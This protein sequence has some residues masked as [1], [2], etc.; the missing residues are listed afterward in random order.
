MYTWKEIIQNEQQKEYY[1][2]LMRFLNQAYEQSTVYP[3]KDQ[4]FT[5]FDYCS[6]E[7]VKV[8]IL[9]QDPYHG[10]HQA[11]GLCFSVLKGTKIPPSLKNIYKEL[12]SDLGID[13]PTHGYLA[14]WAKQ[15]VFLLNAVMSVEA[16]KAG[17]HQKKGWETFTDTI[18]TK[19]NEREKGI[20]FVLWGNWAIKKANLITNPQHVI[21]TSAH[22]SPLSASRGF[23]GSKPFSKVNNALIHMHQTPIDWRIPE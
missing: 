18:I 8:V 5:C 14:S 4:L 23:L 12:K 21:I 11:H 3:P 10:E 20:V 2:K 9:G 1:Q 6:Y 7:D 13:P 15:G 22:P 17:S 19:L 16:N